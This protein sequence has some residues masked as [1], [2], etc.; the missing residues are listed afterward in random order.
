MIIQVLRNALL[1]AVILMTKYFLEMNAQLRTDSDFRLRKDE[2]Y[3]GHSH[4][5]FRNFKF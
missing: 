5:S 2:N 4:S 1:K 3:V